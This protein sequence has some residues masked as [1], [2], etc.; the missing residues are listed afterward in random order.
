MQHSHCVLLHD[1][2]PERDVDTV[3][4][5][6]CVS[7]GCIRASVSETFSSGYRKIVI[8]D[9]R[10]DLGQEEHEANIKNVDRRYADIV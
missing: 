8:E 9:Y 10:G 1:L 7:S 3:L 2:S 6:G 5:T 4:A